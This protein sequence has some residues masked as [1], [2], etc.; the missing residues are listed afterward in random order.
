MASGI[1]LNGYE[2]FGIAK[3]IPRYLIVRGMAKRIP[4]QRPGS[5]DGQAYP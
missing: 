3:R 4:N 1:T 2:V 5:R